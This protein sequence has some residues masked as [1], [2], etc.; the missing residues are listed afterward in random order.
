VHERFGYRREDVG[1]QHVEQVALQP[2]DQMADLF[3]TWVDVPTD[4][5]KPVRFN[6]LRPRGTRRGTLWEAYGGGNGKNLEAISCE[7]VESVI[8]PC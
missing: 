2:L 7:Q 6:L 1:F 3:I 5:T 4:V 8:R